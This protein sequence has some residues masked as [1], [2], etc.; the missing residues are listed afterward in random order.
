MST[1][2]G[3][4]DITKTPRRTREETK[5]SNRAAI[6]EAARHVFAE[7]GYGA[8]TVRDIIRATDLASGTF[9]NYFKS[10]E[11]VF[12]AIQDE[13]ALRLRPRLRAERIRARDFEAFVSGSFRTFFD[14]IYTDRKAFTMMRQPVHMRFRVDTPE[15]LAGF[16]ELRTDIKAAIETGVLP[17]TDADLLMAAFVGVAFEV[18]E[19]LLQRDDLTVKAAAEFATKLFLGGIH[20]LPKAPQ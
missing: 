8:T 10:K 11:E 13:T 6:I 2:D 12:E 5:A 18:G 9:Y 20:A 4:E 14:H 15:V 19:R 16:D 1:T 17:C 3:P 7:L